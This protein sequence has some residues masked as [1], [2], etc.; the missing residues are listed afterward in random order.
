[1]RYISSEELEHMRDPI[2]RFVWERWLK[3]GTAELV[4]EIQKCD[5]VCA[6]GEINRGGVY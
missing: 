5:T 4:E 1:M 3:E 6:N 2:A